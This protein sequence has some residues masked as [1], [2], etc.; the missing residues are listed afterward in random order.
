MSQSQTEQLVP[1]DNIAN[2]REVALREAGITQSANGSYN[3]PPVLVQYRDGI[4]QTLVIEVSN[5]ERPSSITTLWNLAQDPSNRNLTTESPGPPD[6]T[7]D[8]TTRE[9]SVSENENGDSDRQMTTIF[10][11]AAALSRLGL[12]HRGN[13]NISETERE[14]ETNDRLLTSRIVDPLQRLFE[15]MSGQSVNRTNL[16]NS[17]TPTP[18]STP[19]Q[20]QSQSLET[21]VQPPPVRDNENSNNN[22]DENNNTNQTDATSNASNDIEL[23]MPGDSRNIILTVNYIQ[24]G[25]GNEN[26]SGSLLLYVPSIVDTDESNVQLLVRLA[27]EIALRTISTLLQKSA[28]VSDKVFESLKVKKLADLKPSEQECPICYDSYVEKENLPDVNKKRGNDSED[29]ED[30][31]NNSVPPNKRL[32]SNTQESI[33]V[34]TSNSS[35]VKET[36]DSPKETKLEYAHYPVTLNCEHTFGASCLHEWFK[37]NSTC[38]L[39]REKLPNK[40][41]AINT[42]HDIQITLP[43]LARTIRIAR[44]LIDNLNNREMT[45]H[46]REDDQATIDRIL[47]ES[48]SNIL[49]P[50]AYQTLLETFTSLR[51][52]PNQNNPNEN[53]TPVGSR[54]A[55]ATPPSRPT[56]SATSILNFVREVISSMRRDNNAATNGSRPNRSVGVESRR[57]ANGVET[58]DYTMFGQD[59]NRGDSNTNESPNTS[60]SHSNNNS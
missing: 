11:N 24:G 15:R 41:D 19:T 57:T 49:S 54:T 12:F 31:D 46:F 8:L 18:T 4:Y 59:R 43:N 38:P 55:S 5:R 33:P 40:S 3:L 17:N 14:R 58:R 52:L 42:P 29:G 26:G 35:P 22:T 48:D 45:F 21:H 53:T 27:T 36:K 30:G 6:T 20:S 23:R 28:G 51:S 7:S 2:D 32:K 44:T 16:G 50:A 37:T 9:Q 10:Q 1:Q 47:Q 39:C 25:Q 13:D 56:T 34:N 60:D